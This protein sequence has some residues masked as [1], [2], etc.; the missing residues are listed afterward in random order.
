MKS[1]HLWI[2]TLMELKR[3]FNDKRQL[4]ILI[5]GSI[6]ICLAFGFVAH[7]S[8][9]EIK[10][11]VFVDQPQH[12]SLSG[13][14]ETRQIIADI[15]RSDVF[16]VFEAYSLSE[17]M[18]HL[19]DRRSRAVIVLSEGATV[20]EAIQVTIDVT[21]PIIQQAISAELSQ[22]LN[23]HSRH[24][25]IDFLVHNGMSRD[26]ATETIIPIN[27]SM[28]TNEW[29][30]TKYFDF[31]ALP[32]VII[33][34]LGICLL[35]SVTSITSERSKGTIE[36]VFASPYK[37]SE[38]ILSKMAANSVLAII[39]SIFIILTL[40]L[41]F[42]IALAS[43]LWA[44]V[45]TILAGINGV[46]F[47]LLISSVTY[48]ELE[49]VEVGILFWFVFMILMGFIWP[50]ETMHPFFRYLAYLTPYLYGVHAI[51]HVSLVG[52]GLSQIWLDLIILCGFILVQA[53]IAKQ[54]LKREIK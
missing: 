39:S 33:I 23:A 53:L 15:D 43:P 16:S 47:G 19:S 44:V 1:G 37:G 41:V 10:V 36:R 9:Q 5:L 40:K 32:T 38:F 52:W 14:K 13:H 50:L 48:S 17:A 6:L 45:I 25:A 2:M 42:D 11:T 51:R 18:Q 49:S 7:R 24:S 22:I 20:L 34:I 26:Q 21:D 30:N 31:G 27:I 46:I 35:I 4:L 54:M 3:I 12:L 8:P 29:Q 28:Q